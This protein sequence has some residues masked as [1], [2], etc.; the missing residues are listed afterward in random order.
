MLNAASTIFTMD[1][2]REWISNNASQKALVILGRCTIPVLVIIGCLISPVLADPKFKGAFAFIQEFQGF[3]S[4]GIL[5]I[6]L[7]GLF[8]KKAPRNCGILGLVLSPVIY[9]ILF[10][11]WGDMAFL[12]RMAITVGLISGILALV[13]LIFP[14]KEK[15]TLPE[16]TK[17]EMKWSKP[18]VYFGVFVVILTIL[19]YIIFW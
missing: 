5:T 11:G 10:F 1:V 3:I 7:F 8:V 16:Q 19:L 2:Y 18:A 4:P 12:N 6:F 17:I 14:L 9:G 13:T 15:I